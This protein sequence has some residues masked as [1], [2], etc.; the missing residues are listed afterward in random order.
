MRGEWVQQRVD[1]DAASGM[2]PNEMTWEAWYLQG[3]YK[4]LPTKF[5]GVVRYG[6]F[7]TPTSSREQWA[8]GVNYLIANNIIAKL[9]FESNT[10]S[11]DRWLAQLAYGY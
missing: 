4:F 8:F 11:P 6:E 5:E 7:D 3:A 1:A 2:F 9:S 10:G